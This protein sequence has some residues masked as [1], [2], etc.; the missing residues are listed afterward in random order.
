MGI[1][2]NRR[3]PTPFGPGGAAGTG[4][5]AR[6]FERQ[7]IESA[8][9]QA[10]AH[11]EPPF[12]ASI[13]ERVSASTIYFLVNALGKN[14]SKPNLALLEKTY[15]AVHGVNEVSPDTFEVSE[16]A[17]AFLFDANSEGVSATLSEFCKGYDNHFGGL[18]NIRHGRWV[19]STSVP[20][21]CFVFH[22]G[23]RKE[24]GTLEHHL[25]PMVKADSPERY[26]AAERF[27]DQSRRGDDEV[28]KDKAKRLKA[29]I[30][31][32]GQFKLPG[33]AMSAVIDRKS[34]PAE[35]YKGSELSRELAG[36]L[37]GTPW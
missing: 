27:I 20:V 8:K 15:N 18:S 9:L 32:T 25:A 5:I 13:V 16:Y 3:P 34:I 30:T 33:A 17:V 7:E 36:F 11:P 29:V 21:G 23:P 6:Q 35:M 22:E 31:A 28:S 12:F 4:L 14:R 19:T 26:A 37:S 2:A 1:Q 24:Q 10:A